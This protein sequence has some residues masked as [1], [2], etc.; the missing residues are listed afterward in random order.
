MTTY[1]TEETECAGCSHTFTQPNDPGR[2]REYCSDACRQ[3]AY[4]QRGGRASGTRQESKRARQ[5]REQ[6]EQQQ[7]WDESRRH[8]ARQERGRSRTRGREHTDHRP[9][10]CQAPNP[11]DTPTQ[12]KARTQAGKLYDRAEHP[13]TPAPEA[14]S[15]RAKAEKLRADHDL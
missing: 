3:R 8:R 5:E 2:R 12:A 9:P 4:R 13:S 14:D 6:R 11:S 15:C 10:W 1:T 7:A